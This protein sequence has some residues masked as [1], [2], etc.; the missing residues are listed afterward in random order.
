MSR[1]KQGVEQPD[2]KRSS[3][4]RQVGV[5]YKMEIDIEAGDVVPKTEAH[6]NA[7]GPHIDH[8]VID[9]RPK[10]RLR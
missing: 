3:V 9:S 10:L 2:P 6:R 1:D 4:G 5:I 8:S 7:A